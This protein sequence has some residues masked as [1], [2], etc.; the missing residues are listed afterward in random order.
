MTTGG[1]RMIV[2]KEALIDVEIYLKY[3]YLDI[4]INNAFCVGLL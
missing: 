1:D 4:K 3:N 2:Y